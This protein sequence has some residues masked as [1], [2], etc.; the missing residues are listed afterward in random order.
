MELPKKSLEELSQQERTQRLET[1]SPEEAWQEMQRLQKDI[2]ILNA[3]KESLNLTLELNKKSLKQTEKD[4]LIRQIFELDALLKSKTSILPN[5]TKKSTPVLDTYFVMYNQCH[6]IETTETSFRQSFKEKMDAIIA[7]VKS[8]TTATAEILR[9]YQKITS[10]AFPFEGL[11][12]E[13]LF[14]KKNRDVAIAEICTAMN[15]YIDNPQ[16]LKAFGDA[17]LYTEEFAKLLQDNNIPIPPQLTPAILPTQRAMRYRLL[18]E[19]IVDTV[20]KLKTKGQTPIS[21]ETEQLLRGTLD[22][23]KSFSAKVDYFRIK[24]ANDTLLPT[25]PH[26]AYALTQ[27]GIE[28]PVKEGEEEKRKLAAKEVTAIITKSRDPQKIAEVLNKYGFISNKKDVSI[29]IAAAKIKQDYYLSHIT[30]PTLRENT[31]KAMVDKQGN[32]LTDE[33]GKQKVLHATATKHLTLQRSSTV[34]YLKKI[35]EIQKEFA[36]NIKDYE[37]LGKNPKKLEQAAGNLI[38]LERQLT[39]L[40]LSAD[41]TREACKDMRRVVRSSLIEQSVNKMNAEYNKALSYYI[42]GNDKEMN[43]FLDKLKTRMTTLGIKDEFEAVKGAILA[44]AGKIK[45]LAHKSPTV[46]KQSW[47]QHLSPKP[48]EVHQEASVQKK[49]DKP[50]PHPPRPGGSSD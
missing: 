6:E 3:K 38:N 50:L 21:P 11:K 39:K 19:T 41:Q 32:L 17:T 28:L 30:D 10:M 8:K 18:M 29:E 20:D 34:Y 48:S 4:E 44:D 46:P 27:N 22:K 45:E 47:Q 9:P 26:I 15:T 36:K 49:T 1:M 35:N 14:R 13:E 5:V 12:T 40:G 37:L 25:E 7:A 42:A 16:T 23:V 33:N 43:K 31:Q 2:N 24:I